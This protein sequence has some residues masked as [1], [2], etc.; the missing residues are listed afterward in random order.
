MFRCRA[1]P[2]EVSFVKTLMAHACICRNELSDVVKDIGRC[3][4]V[5][6]VSETFCKF[7]KY[8]PVFPCFSRCFSCLAKQLDGAGR[9]GAGS[10]LFR[11]A[12]GREYYVGFLR[13]LRQENILYWARMGE[14]LPDSAAQ[15]RKARLRI[16]MQGYVPDGALVRFSMLGQDASQSFAVMNVFIPQLLSA[17]GVDKRRVLIGT[18]LAKSMRT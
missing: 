3:F 6:V 2:L 11:P 5:P 4:E 14:M 10:R 9:I 16:A 8:S 15:Q 7:D 12:C 13:C 18:D 1:G 17:V